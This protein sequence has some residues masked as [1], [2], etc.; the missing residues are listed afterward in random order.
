MKRITLAL[1]LALGLQLGMPTSVLAASGAGWIS[2]VCYSHTLQQ[3]PITN[4]GPS[5]TL[6]P[7]LHDFLGALTTDSASTP[8]SL[9]AGGTCA[10]EPANS[11]ASWVPS[12][13]I[14]GG[15]TTVVPS[16]PQDKDGLVYYKSPSGLDVRPFPDGFSMIVGNAFA[17]SLADNPDFSSGRSYWK[18]G[19]GSG[20]HLMHPPSQ[21]SSGIM[22]TT[23]TFPQF[24]D[25]VLVAGNE[26]PHMSF[27]RD[28]AHPD[29]LPRVQ[30]Y[31]RYTVGTAPI[32]TVALA[33][34][35]DSTAHAAYLFAWDQAAFGSLVTRCI[36]AGVNCGTNPTP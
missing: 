34:A 4:P 32:G 2:S 35:P 25:G 19:P 9:R 18:C 22:V 33:S 8:D 6:S 1:V 20:T 14:H 13:T 15:A 26:I 31:V 29:V 24:W 36:N 17:T 27:T 7:H 23:Y 21:C 30:I 11:A 3:D 28:A 10:G 16:A 5:G 12:L